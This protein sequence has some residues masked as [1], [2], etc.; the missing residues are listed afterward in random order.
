MKKGFTMIELIFVIVIL[1][2]LAA[3]AVPRL[4]ATRDDAEVAKAATNLTTLVSDITSY[5]TSQ[6]DL[7]SKIKDMTNVQVDE[8]PDLTAELISAGKKCIKVEGKKATDA[9]GA[10]GAT[11]ATL[12][13]SKGDD[14]DK[15]ICSKL[16]K[17]RSISDLLGTDD[18]GKEIQL[19]GTGI[20]Y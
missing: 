2:I 10:T 14:K 4:T 1:G 9:T 6:G 19:G 12:T 11:G 17:M 5:Y 20:N 18:K 7:A 3:V 15:A 16:Y 13:I 8:N